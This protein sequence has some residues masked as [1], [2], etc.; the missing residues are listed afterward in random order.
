MHGRFAYRD[1]EALLS[2]ARELGFEMPYSDDISPLLRP[3]Q[4]GGVHIGNRLVVQPMEG[5]DS[6]YKGSPSALTERRYLRYAGGGSGIIWFE[7]ISVDPEGRSNPR[8]LWLHN[9]NYDSFSYLT[10]KIRKA[11]Q[12][13]GVEPFLVAQLTHSGRYSK[14]EGKPAPLVAAHNPLLDRITPVILSDDDLKRIRD[15]FAATAKLAYRCG[16]NA[17][18]IKSCHG[19]LVVDLL[20]SRKRENSIFGGE[21]TS[22]RFRFLLETLDMIRDESG[23]LFRTLRLNISDVYAGG[24]GVD[25]YGNPDFSEPLKL[26]EELQSA[27]IDLINITMGSPYFNPHVTRPYN[28]PVPGQPLPDEHPLS[29]VDRMLK[30]T[31]LFARRFPRIQ[32]IGSGYS[33]L[34]Q[35]APN[36]GAAVINNGDASFVGFGRS[37]FAYP[38]LPGDLKRSGSADPSKVCIACSGC[39]TLIRNMRPGGCVIRDKGIYGKELKELIHGK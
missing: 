18:D 5:Y 35:F 26:V 32:F 29:G 22:K 15:R 23:G 28:A 11:A 25:D 30:S 39:T 4:A 38:S 17:V 13:E 3:G 12:K 2:K 6:E 16:F 1:K 33:Y 19:Y 20:A 7:A 21:E 27:G 9:K 36:V 37:S 24:F 14:P 31:S 8:Q 10:E 34:R